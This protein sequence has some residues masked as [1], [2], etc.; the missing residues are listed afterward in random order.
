MSYAD[1]IKRLSKRLEAS[2]EGRY[3]VELDFDAPHQFGRR[4]GYA[5][6]DFQANRAMGDWAE[7]GLQE[8]LTLA[9]KNYRIVKY[10]N[11][12]QIIAGDPDFEEFWD[13]YQKEL[14]A[15]GK[16]LDLLI[17][18]SDKYD[19]KWN[20]DISALPVFDL[21]AIARTAACGIEVRSSKY[22]AIEY[23]RIRQDAGK[24]SA[25]R[26]PSFTVKLEDLRIVRRWILAHHVPHF[27]VQVFLDSAYAIPFQEILRLLA[28]GPKDVTLERNKR[29]QNK[30]TFHIPI[31][32]GTQIGVFEEL[33]NFEAV[34][35][36]KGGRIEAYV[37]PT[38][39]ILKIDRSA[40]FAALELD[41]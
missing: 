27:Y 16:R 12:D 6:S 5:S 10:G 37:R 14:A 40:L 7:S 1:A 3:K 25:R 23:M 33:P 41:Q 36:N 35:Q 24:K 9:M 18:R 20:F 11:S 29:N 26:A 19:E 13:S 38:G 17:F 31:T 22:F 8:A 4:P 2:I 15:T 39:G 30:P 28:N 21:P 32:Y 34:V